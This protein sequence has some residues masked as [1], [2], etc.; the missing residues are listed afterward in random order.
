MVD[1][2]E[3]YIF[4]FTRG[5]RRPFSRMAGNGKPYRVRTW[6]ISR[7]NRSRHVLA[8]NLSI[9]NRKEDALRLGKTNISRNVYYFVKVKVNSKKK[10]KPVTII[11]KYIGVRK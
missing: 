11:N 2:E 9:D 5:F 1:K 3:V 7:L 6:I 8:S 4:T 10:K